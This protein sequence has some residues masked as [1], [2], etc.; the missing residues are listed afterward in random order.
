MTLKP[1]DVVSHYRIVE[2]I[3]EGGMGLVFRAEDITL[4]RSVALK[5][6]S[7]ATAAGGG[8]RARLLREARAA[9]ALNHP[10]ICTIYEVHEADDASFIAM[11]LVEG[12]TLHN[13]LG[14]A[15]PLPFG[16]LLDIAVD[17]ADGLA[18]AHARR[19][20]HRD[21]KPQNIMVTPQGRVKI[22]DFGLAIPA[23]AAAAE[24]TAASTSHTRSSGGPAIAGG[25]RGGGLQ[26]TL[27]YMSP[28]QALG[29]EVD[30]RSDLFSFGTV[31]YE[32]ATGRNVLARPR[33]HLRRVEGDA[34]RRGTA[35]RR[36]PCRRDPRGSRGAPR[37]L[38]VSRK[39]TR[40]PRPPR[41][42]PAVPASG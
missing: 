14:R 34:R 24:E 2:K 37:T 27:P 35:S 22:L 26:G 6:L 39:A 28:E 40:R 30:A 7:E 29:K 3:G 9:A 12:E 16:R 21:L 20:V 25:A 15:G 11:E 13:L 36:P 32:M 33:Q 23:P 41:A 17:V 10:N 4:R 1:G 38:S 18:E 42:S 31:L 19:I 8:S 5:V